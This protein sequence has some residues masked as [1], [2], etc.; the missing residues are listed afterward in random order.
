MEACCLKVALI[1]FINNN[2]YQ[3]AIAHMP[4]KGCILYMNHDDDERRFDGV[5]Y[6]FVT[7]SYFQHYQ[8]V[9]HVNDA[10]SFTIKKYSI[11]MAQIHLQPKPN[12]NKS[13]KY[14]EFK[15]II[16]WATLQFH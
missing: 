16:T 2:K 8:T 1:A 12:S 13:L 5:T 6:Q 3:I 14:L 9:A 4:E 15:C 7:Y 10:H 11:L